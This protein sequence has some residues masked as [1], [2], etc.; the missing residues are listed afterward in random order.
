M[1]VQWDTEQ[2]DLAPLIEEIVSDVATFVLPTRGRSSALTSWAADARWVVVPRRPTS[3]QACRHTVTQPPTD[4]L[5]LRAADVTAL[6]SGN[7]TTR[8]H[9]ALGLDELG[10]LVSVDVAIEQVVSVDVATTQVA[11][12][13]S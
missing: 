9:L 3:G 13:A 2:L 5:C 10:V 12:T 7:T 6:A 1:K 8:T 11:A 4:E